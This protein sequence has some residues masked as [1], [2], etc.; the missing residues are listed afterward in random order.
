MLRFPPASPQSARLLMVIVVAVCC[1][2][3]CV[4]AGP[5]SYPCSFDEVMRGEKLLFAAVVKVVPSAGEPQSETYVVVKEEWAPIRIVASMKDLE[6]NNKHCGSP[7]LNRPNLRGGTVS[8]SQEDVLTRN[9]KKEILTSA[10]NVAIKLHADRL[11][12]QP[13]KG[14]LKVP[15]FPSGSICGQFTVPPE[16]NSKGVDNADMVLY[17]A[18]APGGVW[19][20][21]CATLENGRPI[22]GVVNFGPADLRFLRLA[23]RIAAHEIAHA[24]GFDYGKMVASR[25]VTNVTSVRG[26]ALSV[27]V[28]STNAAMAAREHYNCDNIQGMELYDF[29]GDGTTLQSH[30]SH[31]NAKDELMA[32]L[33]GAGYYTELTLAAFADLGYYKVNWAMAEPMGWGRQ[34]GCD[35]LEKKCSELVSKY[36]K[37]FCQRGGPHLRCT[38]DRYFNGT[39]DSNIIEMSPNVQTDVCLTVAALVPTEDFNHVFKQEQQQRGKKGPQGQKKKTEKLPNPTWC[40]DR[41]LPP[42]EEA[43]EEEYEQPD[44]VVYAEVMC[45]GNEVKL[46]TGSGVLWQACKAGDTVTGSRTPFNNEGVICPEHAEVC[47]I[48]VNGSSLLPVVKWNGEEK[49]WK[50]TAPATPVEKPAPV[51]VPVPSEGEPDSGSS[52]QSG[53]P[54]STPSAPGGG[55]GNNGSESG[56]PS[57]EQESIPVAPQGAGN[58]SEHHDNNHGAA[59]GVSAFGEKQPTNEDAADEAGAGGNAAGLDGHDATGGAPGPVELPRR[60][61]DDAAVGRGDGGG[62]KRDASS[63]THGGD[64]VA[65]A[66][67]SPFLLLAIVAAAALY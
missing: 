25:M 39:C 10:I 14:P 1:G 3:S 21:P 17:V 58:G 9:G 35:L 49:V 8:C 46:K 45:A 51:P 29:K 31:R 57:T 26:R 44:A 6:D 48:S 41:N 56:A 37:M 63:P 42:N 28:N 22:V 16:H 30:W 4:A 47:T 23:T 62:G 55:T 15:D 60:D 24:L 64:T 18:A 54:P 65:S 7:M 13:L 40:L 32:P 43:E 11:L 36:P 66:G 5:V 12:V 53:R 34:S 33:G 59:G 67:L 19:A 20:L 61:D 38:S 52:E 2:C 27:V 50:R